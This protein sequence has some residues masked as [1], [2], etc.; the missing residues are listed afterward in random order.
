MER[1]TII[2]DIIFISLIIIIIFSYYPKIDNH[3][4]NKQKNETI[5]NI[6][7]QEVPIIN[8]QIFYDESKL[9]FSYQVYNDKCQGTCFRIKIYND[10]Y[11]ILYN[12]EI[13]KDIETKI[14]LEEIKFIETELMKNN[15]LSPNYDSS[16]F[17][18]ET[19]GGY[20]IFFSNGKNSRTISNINC[21]QKH[22]PDIVKN[23]IIKIYTYNNLT[24]S[25]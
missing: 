13:N 11:T 17:C 20:L 1:K 22:L 12:H 18:T 24:M 14:T 9:F 2:K 10:G 7:N 19:N 3:Y 5:I 23:E 4:K 21:G 6:N 25:S 15:I 8:N 16:R